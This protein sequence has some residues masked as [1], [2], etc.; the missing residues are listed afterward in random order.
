MSS[1]RNTPNSGDPNRPALVG[2]SGIAQEKVSFFAKSNCV[3]YFDVAPSSVSAAVRRDNPR[4]H[5]QDPGNGR[6]KIFRLR[7]QGAVGWHRVGKDR[8]E[9]RAGQGC[10][11]IEKPQ[12][13]LKVSGSAS[14]LVVQAGPSR[15]RDEMYRFSP[16]GV[17]EIDPKT[18]VGS[19]PA[20]SYAV[21]PQQAGLVQLLASGALT[22]NSLG[23]YSCAKKSAFPQGFTAAIPSHSWS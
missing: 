3:R 6:C 18:V 17:I 2:A 14:S 5:R 15:A 23:E 13:T 10:D 16:G 9:G 19:A 21:L 4:H 8:V 12:G 20:A 22:Q 1:V 11:H 7:L